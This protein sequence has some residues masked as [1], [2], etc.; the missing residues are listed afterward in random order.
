MLLGHQN[1]SE[2]E[3]KRII[4]RVNKIRE[5]V[6]KARL[7]LK[8]F[9]L[10]RPLLKAPP[11]HEVFH[12]CPSVFQAW[13]LI[14]DSDLDYSSMVGYFEEM[15]M[16]LQKTIALNEDNLYKSKKLQTHL[17]KCIDVVNVICVLTKS[18]FGD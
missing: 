17:T 15:A 11:K 4:E 3:K 9:T 1:I 8:K 10:T 13:R 14:K 6:D 5:V 7:D 18:K 16:T 2:L 12:V